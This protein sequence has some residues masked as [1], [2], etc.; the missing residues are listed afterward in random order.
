MTDKVLD[1]AGVGF[2]PGGVALAAMI[3][4]AREECDRD[5]FGLQ[6]VKFFERRPD[7]AWHS[8]FLLP[9]TDINHHVFRDLATPRDPR[10][11]FTFANYLK[12]HDR[13][14]DFGLLGRAASRHEW[15]DYILWAAQQLSSYVHY[16]NSVRAIH[17]CVE[18]GRVVAVKL[19]GE[20]GCY[21]AR[22]LVLSTGGKAHVPEEFRALICDRVF[23]TKD[24]L[25]RVERFQQEDIANVLVVGSGQSAG[26]AVLELR[27]RFKGARIYSLHRSTGFKL[28]DLG[29]FGQ[30]VFSPPETEYFYRLNPE[31]RRLN[32]ADT[33]QTNYSGLDLSLSLELYSQMY[34]D[35]VVNQPRIVMLNRRRIVDVARHQC[36]FRV[37][38]EDIYTGDKQSL[39][40]DMIVLGIGY[41]EEPIPDLLRHLTDAIVFD[42][43]GQP[44]ITRD[45]RVV[46]TADC[47]VAIY[48]NGLCERTH[49]I[50]DGQSFSMITLRAETIIRSLMAREGEELAIPAPAL[51]SV[52]N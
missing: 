32:F 28:Y 52:A 25:P 33:K 1:L 13:L 18:N 45:Y 20:Q 19:I 30:Q 35:R 3:E 10:S 14:Y 46:T 50:S 7:S 2:G 34:E 23:H 39:A 49:G 43:Q 21:L 27:K 37:N 15:S 48:L 6:S 44:A 12:Q 47:D 41:L 16:S 29:S 31:A 22:N 9:D 4:D 24:F 38:V 26:E 42:D 5:L 11:R 36:G 17:P 8:D 51:A 40:V